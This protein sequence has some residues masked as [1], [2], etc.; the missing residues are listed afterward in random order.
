[1]ADTHMLGRVD[2]NRECVDCGNKGC[3]AELRKDWLPGCPT[4]WDSFCIECYSDR[5][6]D[7]DSGRPPKPPGYKRDRGFKPERTTGDSDQARR[8]HAFATEWEQECTIHSGRDG[9]S[10]V[11]Q[12]CR[13]IVNPEGPH[14]RHE[15]I[16]HISSEDRRIVA[17]MIQW[18]GTNVGWDFL[19][20]AL[21]RAG[22]EIV[23]IKGEE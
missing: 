3:I 14:P 11:Q 21:R 8:E 19:N 16:V 23:R 12:V 22:Y 4:D 6:E 7:M 17:T 10:L 1:M 15:L 13:R 2:M 9:H 18:L 5:L 20:R